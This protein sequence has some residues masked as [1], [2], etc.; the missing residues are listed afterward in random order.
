MRKNKTQLAAL[1]IAPTL[2]MTVSALL[3]LEGFEY[4]QVLLWV[5]LLLYL[6]ALFVLVKDILKQERENQLLWIFIVLIFF[7]VGA[8]VYVARR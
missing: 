8:L 3:K 4:A 6:Y 7:P 1:V 2:L 5:S